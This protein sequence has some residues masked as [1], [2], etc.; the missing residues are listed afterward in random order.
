MAFVTWPFL[1]FPLKN[2]ITND[3][4]FSE[5]DVSAKGS[6]R[7][8][9]VK[10]MDLGV[11]FRHFVEPLEVTAKPG[12]MQVRNAWA[13]EGMQALA[14][15]AVLGALERAGLAANEIDCIIVSNSTTP[16]TPGAD[17]YLVNEIPLRSDI[18]RIPCT[19]LGCVGGA[20]ALALAA[21][22]ADGFPGMKVLVVVPEALS[23]VYQSED[24]TL[25]GLLWRLFF[26]DSAAACIVS[27]P[28]N[29]RDERP[30][31]GACMKI[32]AGWHNVVK[33][34]MGTYELKSRATGHHFLSKS[35]AQ[36]AVLKLQEPLSD[37]LPAG[38]RPETVIGHP[39]G[40]KVL[41]YMADML[42]FPE[43]PEDAGNPL[44]HSWRSLRDYG[45]L[46]GA[47]VLHILAETAAHSPRP[48]SETLLLA[49]GPGVVGGATRGHMLDPNDTPAVA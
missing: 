35:G 14:K 12:D 27:S 17:V 6:P 30:P 13:L 41:R 11:Q 22:L 37:W 5:M 25:D 47:A 31:R 49:L 23:V 43:D 10:G 28:Q 38:W 33:G 46:G 15:E 4:I 44:G 19:Q 2:R 34:T 42:G 40:P 16:A 24:L 36:H 39:G 18:L 48:G 21:K 9:R 8:E 29:V 26:G 20:H 32:D 3:D 45:N 1:A 7:L